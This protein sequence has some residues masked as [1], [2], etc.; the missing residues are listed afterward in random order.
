MVTFKTEKYKYEGHSYMQN[1]VNGHNKRMI[2]KIGNDII[3]KRIIHQS[4]HAE[5]KLYNGKVLK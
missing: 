5:G 4:F 2:E 3:V 1:L